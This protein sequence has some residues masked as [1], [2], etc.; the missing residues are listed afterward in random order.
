MA[1]Y[2]RPSNPCALHSAEL[3]K[4]GGDC[5]KWCST[6]SDLAPHHHTGVLN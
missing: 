1:T 2:G 6:P 4:S 3:Q 5:M